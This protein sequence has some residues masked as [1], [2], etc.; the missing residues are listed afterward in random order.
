MTKPWILIYSSFLTTF[1]IPE[2]NGGKKK[3]IWVAYYTGFFKKK[4]D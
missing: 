1:F 4:I 3:P 2:Q